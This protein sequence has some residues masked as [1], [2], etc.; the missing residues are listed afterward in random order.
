MV[1]NI[2]VVKLKL[3]PLMGV[4]ERLNVNMDMIKRINEMN[5]PANVRYLSAN[6]VK[7]DTIVSTNT[8]K[9]AAAVRHIWGLA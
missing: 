7:S 4:C 9:L 2:N 8:A 5:T 6:G 1:N 3:L